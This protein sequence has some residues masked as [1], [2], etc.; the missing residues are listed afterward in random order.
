MLKQKLSVGV[1]EGGYSSKNGNRVYIWEILYLVGFTTR[2]LAYMV[3][4]V[5]WV[6][7]D[8]SR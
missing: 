1:V 4:C 2:N 8:F 6:E 5:Q 3:N 7:R